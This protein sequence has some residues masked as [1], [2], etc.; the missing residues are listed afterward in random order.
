MG[1]SA[2]WGGVVSALSCF[3]VEVVIIAA[4]LVELITVADESTYTN[5]R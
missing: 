1:K 2:E 5:T 3:V 4:A